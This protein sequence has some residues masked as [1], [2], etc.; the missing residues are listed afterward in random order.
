MLSFPRLNEKLPIEDERVLQ[1]PHEVFVDCGTYIEHQKGIIS[2]WY[3]LTRV[4]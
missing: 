2:L 4:I 3:S 1:A